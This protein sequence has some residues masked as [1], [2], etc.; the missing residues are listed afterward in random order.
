ML[1]LL[2]QVETDFLGREAFQ[3]VDLAAFYAPIT[4]WSA[5]VNRADRLAEF[6]ARGLRI[7]T[8]GRPGPV[9]LA[10]PADILG[11]EVSDDPEARVH[12][13]AP[14][15]PGPEEVQVRGRQARRRAPPRR[16]RRRRGAGA[17]EALVSFAEAWGAGVYAAFR[18]QDVFPNEHPNYLGHLTLGTPP[19]TLRA[20]EEADLVLVVGCRLSEVT[21]QSYCAPAR[22]PGGDPGRRGPGRGRRNGPRRG[23]RGLRRRGRPRRARRPGSCSVRR[24]GT[25]PGPT[26]PTSTPARSRRPALRRGS[27]RRRSSAPCA[28]SCPRTRC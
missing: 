28:R 19:E 4:K 14:G 9:M 2:G 23:R 26:G 5:T 21:T 8:S 12:D 27:T 25:G 16:D 7:A 13:P 15:G 17:R 18:R 11:E 24:R 22:G 20:L 6:V 3:E 10:L 1:V